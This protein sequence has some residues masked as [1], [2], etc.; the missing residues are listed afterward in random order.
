M[1]AA[2]IEQCGRI[3]SG[4]RRATPS[5]TLLTLVCFQLCLFLAVIIGVIVYRLASEVAF[6]RF[7]STRPNARIYV[8]LTAAVLNLAVLTVLEIFYEKLALR[9]TEWEYPRTTKD[10]ESSFTFKVFMFEFIN[11][12]SFLFYIAFFKGR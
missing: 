1:G 2:D 4:R 5:D 9:L 6:R 11:Y 3:V 7:D 10:F 12:Y 8:T